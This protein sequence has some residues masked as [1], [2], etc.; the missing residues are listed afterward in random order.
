VPKDEKKLKKFLEIRK[1]SEKRQFILQEKLI[2]P[3]WCCCTLVVDSRMVAQNV[4]DQAVDRMWQ[5]SVDNP[6]VEA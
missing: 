1:I 3:E 2:R 6:H 5:N 4:C